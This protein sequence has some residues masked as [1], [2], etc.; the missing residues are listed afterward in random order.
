MY[1]IF[2]FFF[3]CTYYYSSIYLFFLPPPDD[4]SNNI[5][6]IYWLMLP[7]YRQTIHNRLLQSRRL[8]TSSRNTKIWSSSACLSFRNTILLVLCLQGAALPSCDHIHICI[9]RKVATAPCDLTGIK[10]RVSAYM[11]GWGAGRLEVTDIRSMSGFSRYVACQ[12]LSK[13]VHA[14]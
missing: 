11:T 14:C 5:L 13:N 8:G 1:I 7:G 3:F 2:F 6:S 4:R 12:K 10:F 9:E